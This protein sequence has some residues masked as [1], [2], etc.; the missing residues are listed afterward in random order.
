VVLGDARRKLALAADGT[1]D[2]IILDAFSSDAIPVHL[3][4]KEAL[5]LYVRKLAPGG[6][7]AMHVSNVHLDLPPL[8]DRMAADHD[9]PLAVRYADDQAS[10]AEKADGK[11]ASQWMV[12]ARG[13]ADLGA[14]ARGPH[15]HRVRDVRPGPV[16]RDDFANLLWAWK[17]KDADGD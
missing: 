5:Q 17:R 11:T 10:E 16:W 15:W 13:D 4:T 3:L 1:F 9:P 8:V 2:V 6:V 12:L 7:L 14:M